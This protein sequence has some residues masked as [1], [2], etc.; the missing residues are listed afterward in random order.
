[1]HCAWLELS[2]VAS[3]ER[4]AENKDRRNPWAVGIGGT[5]VLWH[6]VVCSFSL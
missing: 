1:M 3:G 4:P 6:G 5:I 2:D